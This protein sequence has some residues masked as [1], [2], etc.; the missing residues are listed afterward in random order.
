MITVLV[1]LRVA[2]WATFEAA[3]DDPRRLA[4]RRDGG[5]VSHQV[6]SRL[7]DP[8]DLVFWDAWTMPQDADDYYHSDRF[9]AD[10]DAM[11]ATLVEVVKLEE[12]E[13]EDIDFRSA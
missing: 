10:L 5:N 12:T 4:L 13:A 7:D 2:D 11:G 1:R 8:T 6:L 9:N 3:H